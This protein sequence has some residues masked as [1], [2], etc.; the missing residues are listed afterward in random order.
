MDAASV[1]CRRDGTCTS[2][3]VDGRRP[4][5]PLSWPFPMAIPMGKSASICF[6]ATM[7][8]GKWQP[9][10]VNFPEG[11]RNAG[12]PDHPGWPSDRT[13]APAWFGSTRQLGRRAVV[14]SRTTGEFTWS[15]ARPCQR[16]P[17]H[18]LSGAPVGGAGRFD[19]CRLARGEGRS[20]HSLLRPFPGRRWR[21]LELR[22]GDFRAKRR[23]RSRPPSNLS[24]TVSSPAGSNRRCKLAGPISGSPIASYSPANGW[25]APKGERDSLAGDHESGR[26]YFG[27][28]LMPWRGGCLVVY[29][30]GAIG[31]S[32]EI[33]LAW[34][35]D[36]KSGFMEFK[37]IS[38]PKKGFEHLY[39]RLVRSGE[40]E[41][42][43]VYNR[44]KIRRSPMEPRVILG[45]VLVARIGIP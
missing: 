41:V 23:S 37:K 24:P 14:F 25:T 5:Q 19:L 9:V 38:E 21:Y 26:F 28:D 27:F 3:A 42:A 32:P 4:G 36:L 1:F 43:V 16:R 8:G 30:K 35:E 7:V 12:T 18:E 45:D 33:V 20:D 10:D 34:S 11:T 13:T 40:N 22:P 29:S 2:P 44:R 6:R 15:A 39:P 17:F 31:V